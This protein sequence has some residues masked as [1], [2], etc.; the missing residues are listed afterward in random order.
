MKNSYKA[1]ILAALGLTAAVAAQA[2][3]INANDLVLGFTSDTAGS[4]YIIDLGQLP[5]AA[6]SSLTTFS[7]ASGS[8]FSTALTPSGQSAVTSLSG[9]NAGV[10]AGSANPADIFVSVL[11]GS[12]QP[13]NASTGPNVSSAASDASGLSLGVVAHTGNSFTSLIAADPTTA[14][15]GTFA[16]LTGDNPLS[17]IG[18]GDSIT[19][20]LWKDVLTSS[21]SGINKK[22]IQ[23]WTE[24]GYVNIAQ[25]GNTVAVGYDEAAS[26]SSVPEPTTY[27]LIA[28]AGLLIVALRNKLARKTA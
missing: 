20:D 28:G 4:D 26:I 5:G 25:F 16:Q 3:Q 23:T 11:D 13:A 10:V 14:A 15:T 9:I 27:G 18:S 1:A 21:G 22:Y 17:T 7:T 12:A 6:T 24:E 8:L 2:Q 19:L